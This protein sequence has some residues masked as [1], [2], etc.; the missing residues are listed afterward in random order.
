MV[1]TKEIRSFDGEVRMVTA[2]DGKPTHIEGY[3]A[4]FNKRSSDLGGFQEVLLPGA[5][6]DV[7]GDDV[8]ALFN[9]RSDFILGRTKSGTLELVQDER[10]LKYRV[11]LPD[12]QVG[13]D[14][15]ESIARGDVD[16]SS[17]AIIIDSNGEEWRDNEE[18]VTIRTISKVKRLFDVGPVCFPAYP[19]TTAAMR[20]M[21]QYMEAKEQAKKSSLDAEAAERER[22]IHIHKISHI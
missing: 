10:G 16:G 9:H 18:G 8:S 21:E 13:R 6:S 1:R 20:S 4:V 3:A 11:A 12:T 14:L 22:I 7:L 15:A 2:D 5:F 17:F 19:G